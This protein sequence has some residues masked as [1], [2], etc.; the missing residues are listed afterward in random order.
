MSYMSKNINVC[1]NWD[2]E[3]MIYSTRAS[4]TAPWVASSTPPGKTARDTGIDSPQLFDTGGLAYYAREWW[5]LTL[6][7]FGRRWYYGGGGGYR[8]ARCLTVEATNT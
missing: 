7:N 8:W 3:K 5:Y 1:M 4:E 2:N 6:A